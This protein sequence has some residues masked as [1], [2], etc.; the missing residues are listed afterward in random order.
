MKRD[1]FHAHF[2]SSGTVVLPVIHVL[3]TEQTL[4]NIRTLFTEGAH[5]CFLINHDFSIEPFL[6]IIRAARQAF[7]SL[8]LGVNFLGLYAHEAFSELARL[9]KDNVSIDGY[10]ADDARIN[11]T[12]LD[13]SEAEVIAI[14]RQASGWRGLYF[15]GTA[16]KYQR[17]VAP[18]DYSSAARA[19]TAFMDVVTTTGPGTGEAADPAKID[20]F[21]K[22]A[23]DHAIAVASG[24][25]PEN[26]ATFSSADCFI[27]ATGIN[28]DGDFYN[29][30]PDRLRDLL[31][32]TRSSKG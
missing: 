12:G 3:D 18:E 27:V 30:D 9:D 28:Y 5:G 8:W 14:A 1:Q 10:W 7:P 2:R 24:I 13:Q 20:A 17:S 15:G 4:T 19:A 23:G 25:T 29:I 26:A 11:E 32:I 21:R 31:S 22:G 6:P 16:F